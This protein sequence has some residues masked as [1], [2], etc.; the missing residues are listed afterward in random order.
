M[1]HENWRRNVDE[2]K[3]AKR[4][5]EAVALAR[6]A[7]EAGHMGDR[8]ALARLGE[9]AGLTCD[10][11]LR[12][13][14]DVESKMDPSDLDAH[15]ELLSVYRFGPEN[16]SFEERVARGNAHHLKAAELGAGPSVSLAQARTYR[17]GVLGV[18]AD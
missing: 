10:D 13:I 8:I 11:V 6:A 15:L 16:L 12:I 5:D 1:M 14:E 7:I 4:Y 2:L 17:A 18:P 9:E 3:A